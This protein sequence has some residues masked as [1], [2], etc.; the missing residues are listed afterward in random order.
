MAEQALEPR[1]NISGLPPLEAPPPRF[2]PQPL[3]GD[4]APAQSP[5]QPRSAASTIPPERRPLDISGVP[6]VERPAPK[7]MPRP[8]DPDQNGTGNVVVDSGSSNLRE[9][10][11]AARDTNTIVGSGGQVFQTE[12]VP[13]M[14]Q[15]L[16][17]FFGRGNH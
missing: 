13:S 10:A 12:P 6:E 11:P 7:F 16:L 14:L 17:G 5:S 3:G 1:L 4:P 15:R 8:Y 9:S 2:M